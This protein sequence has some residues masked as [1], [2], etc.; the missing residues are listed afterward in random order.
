MK[1]GELRAAIE[2]IDDDKEFVVVCRHSRQD[3]DY[4]TD[5]VEQADGESVILFAD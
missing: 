4:P 3:Y 2:G 5:V 1:I